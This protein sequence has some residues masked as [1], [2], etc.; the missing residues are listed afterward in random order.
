MQ[1]HSSAPAPQVADAKTLRD[2]FGAFATGVT[3]I[4]TGGEVPHAMTA[5][6]FTS[7]SLDPPLLL[8]CVG[9]GAVMH[10]CITAAT[11]FGVSVLAGHQEAEARHFADRYRPLGLAQFADVE[12]T[13]GEVT[14]VPLIAG[15]AARFECRVWRAYDGGDHTIFVGEV[16]SLR[17]R[18]DCD[19][20][21]VYRGRFGET[22][23]AL[24]GVS[25]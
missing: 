14:G 13:P 2:A 8:V 21:L 4:T 18:D 22:S 9:K 24:Q 12:V 23:P 17:R 20:L 10:Q 6:S 15:A 19:G 11:S 16:L 3:V 1:L 5:N 25:A 7:V